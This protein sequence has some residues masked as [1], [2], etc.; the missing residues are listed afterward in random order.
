MRWLVVLVL[1]GCSF[2]GA[3][4]S[5]PPAK[6]GRF[7][8]SAP[9]TTTVDAPFAVGGGVAARAVIRD[10]TGVTIAFRHSGYN[11]TDK[12]INVVLS[13]QPSGVYSAPGGETVSA[14]AVNAL[15]DAITD[16]HPADRELSCMAMNDNNDDIHVTLAGASPIKLTTTSS[17]THHLPWNVERD[18]KHFYQATHAIDKQVMAVLTELDPVYF[19]AGAHSVMRPGAAPFDV[20]RADSDEARQCAKDAETVLAKLGAAATVRVASLSC[21]AAPFS[22]CTTLEL[23]GSMLWNGV[24][25]F[26]VPITCKNGRADVPAATIALLRPLLDSAVLRT[27][28]GLA[29]GA[30]TVRAHRTTWKLVGVAGLD[31]VTYDP[32]TQRVYTAGLASPLWPALGIT[33]IPKQPELTLDGK[34]AN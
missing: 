17:C 19:A 11:G 21:N 29:P 31:D 16:L 4:G 6:T 34:L 24:G 14:A 25:V 2:L 23:W 26:D 22:D 13:R 33:D 20:A 8:G 9:V 10:V 30:V 28:A 7:H 32:A 15:A 18:G 27:I 5:A 12:E 3:R 1:C